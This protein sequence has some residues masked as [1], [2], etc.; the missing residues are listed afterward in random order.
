M[1]T[2]RLL[3]IVIYLLNHDIVS[4]AKLAARFNVS[5]RT[6]LR[7]IED[8]SLAG[9]PIQSFSGSKGGYKIMEG[10]KLDGRLLNVE[11]SASITMALKGFL[12]AY[13]GS[14]YNEAFEKI[15]SMLVMQKPQIQSI[16]YD[17][18]ASGENMAIQTSLKALENAINDKNAVNLVYVNA[19]GDSSHRLVEP[20][21]LNY[22]WYAWYLLAFCTKSQ[23]YR[24]FKVVRISEL[25]ATR[26]KFS[27]KHEEASILLEKVFKNRKGKSIEVTLLCKAEVKSA[28]CEYLNG[29]ITKTLENGDFVMN[30]EAMED[31]R[32]WFA[33]LL[34]FGEMITVLEPESLKTRL[35]DTAKKILSNYSK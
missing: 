1:K 8:I 15:S 25:E 5:K 30:I 31:E 34:S 18:G 21:A 4:A 26:I 16:F 28:I 35:M 22:R 24:I 9:I 12:S 13:D 20:I 27:K 10:Y 6:I 19:L 7:D 29:K 32:I 2:E 11:D 14:R 3:S 17:F 23:D 33:V